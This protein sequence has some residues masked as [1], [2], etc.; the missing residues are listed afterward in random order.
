MHA[1][2]IGRHPFLAEHLARFFARLGLSTTAAVGLVDGLRA[3]GAVDPVPPAVVLCEYDVL[4]TQSLAEWE[5]HPVLASVPIFAVS[6]TRRP[7]EMNLLDVNGI[8]GSLYLPTLRAEDAARILGV[9]WPPTR[10]VLPS[11]FADERPAAHTTG[12]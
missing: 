4:T 2:C 1:L 8:A 12:R 5:R 3:A 6:L 10:Y 11:P 9:A 7:T